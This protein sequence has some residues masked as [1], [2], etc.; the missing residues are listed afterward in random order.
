MPQRKQIFTFTASVLDPNPD[1]QG[2]GTFSRILIQIQVKDGEFRS[3]KYH[4]NIVFIDIKL[5]VLVT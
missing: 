5:N 2:T 4:K 1:L 3:F